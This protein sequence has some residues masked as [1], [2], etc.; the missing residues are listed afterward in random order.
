[1]RKIL[2]WLAVAFAVALLCGGC[3]TPVPKHTECIHAS[4]W[5]GSN[6]QRRMMNILSP[7]M[8]EDKFKSYVRWMEGRGCNTVHCILINKG[9][10]EN[11]GYNCGT[12][13]G[14]QRVAKQRIDYLRK[15]GLAVVVWLITDDSASFAKDLFQNAATRIK[16]MADAGLF[17]HAS[18]VV[19]GLE[20]NEY[21]TAAEWQK[22]R[23]ALKAVWKG[24][25]GV[26]HTSGNAF[27]YADLGDII[28]GQ[29]DPSKATEAAIKN[30]IA[31]IKGKGKAAVGFEYERHADRQKATWALD[32]GA[33]GVGNW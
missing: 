24:K 13:A 3:L 21:G 10:G 33:V 25:I 30:Q 14:A 18:Y 4:C 16:S 29:L 22:V 26:H 32:A 15:R 8:S 5:D 12:D 19:L 11:A 2:N 23:A 31:I 20:M 17:R 28:L 9:D 7:G 6:A 27:P 1:M